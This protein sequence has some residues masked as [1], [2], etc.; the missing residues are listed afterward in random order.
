MY[1][2]DTA[3]SV[4]H[5]TSGL[6]M[7]LG[8]AMSSVHIYSIFYFQTLVQNLI[9]EISNCLVG[10]DNILESAMISVYI[11]SISPFL[12]LV[13]DGLSDIFYC[14]AVVLLE[15]LLPYCFD[16]FPHHPECVHA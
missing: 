2:C 11:H 16:Q 15:P 14:L 12:S 4:F 7:L 5:I 8:S 9:S 1:H 13:L 3:L 6:D 10:L